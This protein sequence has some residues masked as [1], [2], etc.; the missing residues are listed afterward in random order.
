MPT[1]EQL[2]IES[3]HFP[4]GSLNAYMLA[5]VLVAAA[6][7]FRMSIS[8]WMPGTQFITILPGI[9]LTTLICGM[10]AGFFAVLLSLFAAWFLVLP[11]IFSFE[12]ERASD[13]F[14]LF[15]FVAVGIV[16]VLVVGAMRDAVERMR[17]LNRTLTTV[18]EANPDAIVLVNRG[19]RIISINQQTADLFAAAREDL[20]GLPLER[21]LP[22]RY[23]EQ[24]VRHRMDFMMG[25][26]GVRAMGIGLKLVGLRL[27]GSEFPVDVQIGSIDLEGAP[28]AIATVRDLTQQN[29]LNEALAE[30]RQQRAVLEERQRG[31]EELRLWADAF[32]SASIGIEISDPRSGDI[33]FVNPAFAAAHGTTMDEA[34]GRSV[35]E[36]YAEE[37]RGRLPQLFAIA[38]GT[39]H[40]S[41]ESRH[42]R[43]DGSTFPVQIDMTSKRDADGTVAYR[44]TSSRDTTAAKQTEEALRQAQK[45]EAIGNITGGMAHDFNNLLAVIIGNLDM[46]DK[47][48]IENVDHLQA[49]V[50]EARDA[51]TRG[52]ELTRS[53]LAFARRQS[54]HPVRVDLN[55]LASGMS[56]LLTR[57]L[58]EDIEIALDLAP[59]LW[60]VIADAAQVEASI[61]NLAN[62]ARDAMPK[63]GRLTISSSN[64]HLDA[65]Y[66]AL[67]PSVKT[68]DY[69][70]LCVSDNGTGMPP[71]IVAKIFEPFFTTKEL[72]KGTGL[73]LSMV[74]GFVK[75]S[76]GHVSVYSEIGF[77]TAVRL[78]L[79]RHVDTAATAESS[80]TR[81]ATVPRRGNGELVLIVE[82]NPNLRRVVQIQLTS[83]N[84]RTI[85]TDNAKAAMALLDTQQVDLLFSDVVMPGGIDGFELAEQA[86]RQWPHLKTLLTSGFSGGRHDATPTREVDIQ[87]LSKPYRLNELAT[88]IRKSLDG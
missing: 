86:A 68:G 58:G 85:E 25:H 75:Q 59:D 39:G 74:F 87:V 61:A 20:V 67:N 45:M 81:S 11:P 31:A 27:D 37:E 1:L 15:V 29:A 26:A 24:H 21:L 79:P 17:G 62:N 40:V 28:I 80:G 4:P 55:Q 22:E 53:L 14:G 19:G 7:A 54:L 33:R 69:A 6:I 23:R 57:V 5:A 42:R 71:D 2:H 36:I 66:A 77:G 43:A 70:M 64:A 82:D 46:V 48:A 49:L 60:P 56:R 76:N 32:Q 34:R 44:L 8:S 16:D 73:G 13:G 83:L 35:V 10:K 3:R 63:G 84:Y 72:G 65:N 12:L 38:D 51:A 18:F 9:L 30:S 47:V 50:D 52:A 41:F 78:Y 88:A